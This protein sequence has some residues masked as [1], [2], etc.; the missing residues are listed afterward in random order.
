VALPASK[1]VI[2]PCIAIVGTAAV[3]LALLTSPPKMPVVNM[4]KLPKY[5][6]S[7]VPTTWIAMNTVPN[8]ITLLCEI[9]EVR[10]RVPGT[11]SSILRSRQT[12]RPATRVMASSGASVA[13]RERGE[14]IVARIRFLANLAIVVDKHKV[15]LRA[16]IPV[17]C[18]RVPSSA[19]VALLFTRPPKMAPR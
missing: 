14:K 13:L 16:T 1:A 17:S 15:V 6:V 10:L 2:L 19:M 8:Q 3:V 5:L 18:K 7:R 12:Q 11:G 4:P 9:G